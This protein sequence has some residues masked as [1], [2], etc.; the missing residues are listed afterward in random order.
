MK[1]LKTLG[2]S[3]AVTALGTSLA[4]SVG[5]QR[6]YAM[7]VQQPNPQAALA[8][9]REAS[10][11]VARLPTMPLAKGLCSSDTE[12]QSQLDLLIDRLRA[13]ENVSPAQIDRALEGWQTLEEPAQE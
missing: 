7:A 3:T 12:G 8:Q 9:L 11:E 6:S 4:S 5:V 2:F 10:D 13:G 1:S